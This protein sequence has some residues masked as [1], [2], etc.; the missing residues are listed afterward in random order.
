MDTKKFEAEFE[1]LLKQDAEACLQLITGM[2]VGLTL[3][4][5]RRRGFEIDKEIVI[6]GNEKQRAITIH[7]INSCSENLQI[8]I[9]EALKS[10]TEI[11]YF[12]RCKNKHRA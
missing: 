10:F 7:A 4:Y 9:N 1:E 5:T 12:Y 3:E 2:F 11:Q 6:E 8:K